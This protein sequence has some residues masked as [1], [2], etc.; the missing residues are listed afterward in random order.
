MVIVMAYASLTLV[1]MVDKTEWQ[2]I[3]YSEN[4]KQTNISS[5]ADSKQKKKFGNNLGLCMNKILFTKLHGYAHKHETFRVFWVC[6]LFNIY[7]QHCCE[8]G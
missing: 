6:H 1:F 5:D 2:H 8:S 4:G 3:A 7:G